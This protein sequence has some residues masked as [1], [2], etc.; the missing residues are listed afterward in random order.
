MVPT[1][2]PSRKPH[3]FTPTGQLG[4]TRARAFTNPNERRLTMKRLAS[5]QW[6][7]IRFRKV[8]IRSL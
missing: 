8:E 6:G 3:G 1:G 4:H 5:M 7:T 2:G